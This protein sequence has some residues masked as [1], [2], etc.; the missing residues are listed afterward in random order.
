MNGKTCS[1]CGKWKSRH[2]KSDKDHIFTPDN[3]DSGV[4]EK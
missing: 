3:F 1:I 4:L 2:K